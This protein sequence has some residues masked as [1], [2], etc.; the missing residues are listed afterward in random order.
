LWI[1][2]VT[3]KRSRSSRL[4]EM[5]VLALHD[6]KSGETIAWL[7]D[8][9]SNWKV[10]QDQPEPRTLP[11]SRLTIPVKR[12]AGTASDVEWWDTRE[13]KVASR[14]KGQVAEGGLVI[15]VPAVRRDVAMRAVV[16][17]K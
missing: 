9:R 7:Q 6:G 5:R 11:A 4:A 2:S 16:A 3:V 8:P 13:G 1:E 10:D 14:G 17:D 15:D 12:P